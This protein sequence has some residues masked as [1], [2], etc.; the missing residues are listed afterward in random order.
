VAEPYQEIVLEDAPPAKTFTIGDE[1]EGFVAPDL[2]G[3]ERSLAE[4]RG[5][6]V[7]LVNWNP[8][9]GYCRSLHKHI[10][11]GRQRCPMALPRSS[12]SPRARRSRSR[13]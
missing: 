1:L 9:C 7:Y 5:R 11:V 12:S 13:P 10:L 3:T 4:L 8:G 6:R 2:D